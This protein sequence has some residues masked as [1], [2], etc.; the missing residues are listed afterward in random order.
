MSEKIE[1]KIQVAPSTITINFVK[2]RAKE[3]KIVDGMEKVV[4]SITP[5]G[6]PAF[7]RDDLTG[8][9][10]LLGKFDTSKKQVR[11]WGAWAKLRRKIYDC[12][13]DGK[14]TMD[15]T[16]QEAS[17]LRGFLENFPKEEGKNAPMHESEVTVREALLEQLPV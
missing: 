16:I 11:D 13:V 17:F 7:I 3:R 15:L 1:K 2:D 14:T 4:D 6:S 5:D 9:Q 10:R 8:L 12:Y